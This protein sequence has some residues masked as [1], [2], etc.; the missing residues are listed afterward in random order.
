MFFD[1]LA[2]AMGLFASVMANWPSNEIYTYGSATSPPPLPPLHPNLYPLP[3]RHSYSRVE[4][5]SGFA[6]GLFL[7]LISIFIVFEAI[8]RLIDPPEMN[9]GQ[10]LTV[11]SVGLAVNLVGMA[12]TGGH[13]GHSHGGG[14]GGGHSHGHSHVRPVFLSSRRFRGGTTLTLSSSFPL[15]QAPVKS[16]STPFLV[17]KGEEEDDH[18][19]HSVRFMPLRYLPFF[20]LTPFF[21]AQRLRCVSFLPLARRSRHS[22]ST[23]SSTLDPSLL[24][25]PLSRSLPLGLA[26]AFSRRSFTFPSGVTFFAFTWERRIA[27]FARFA[28]RVRGG[29]RGRACGA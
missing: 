22:S 29:G 5:L 18:H 23:T 1:C 7:C 28:R 3:R 25:F 9:T 2:L 26:F 4:T 19:D 21:T 10:L 13:H 11:S 14:G 8:Q 12:A 6:N 16:K 27:R 15:S 24:P 17:E 20:V